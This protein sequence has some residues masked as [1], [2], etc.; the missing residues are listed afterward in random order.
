MPKL[1]LP[2]ALAFV[3]LSTVAACGGDDA[4]PKPD[5][6][7]ADGS[8]S[9][10]QLYCIPSPFYDDGG[11]VGDAGVECSMCADSHGECPSGCTPVG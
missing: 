2:D 6:S 3:V 8:P 10:C 1:R 7:L 5:A 4:G 11:P 9:P